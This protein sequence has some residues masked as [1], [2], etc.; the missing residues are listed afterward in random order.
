VI[1][2]VYISH[3]LYDETDIEHYQAANEISK[4]LDSLTPSEQN[5]VLVDVCRK[6]KV[7]AT[8]KSPPQ[9]QAEHDALAYDISSYNRPPS[10]PLSSGPTLGPDAQKLLEQMEREPDSEKRGIVETLHEV[11]PGITLY[12]PRIQYAGDLN[13]RMKTRLFRQA[14]GELISAERIFPPEHNRSTNTRTYEYR[15]R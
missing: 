7:A 11:E 2:W 1:L 15:L 13:T 6:I 5:R 9:T 4:P 10:G 3:C 8:P 14:V 12:F